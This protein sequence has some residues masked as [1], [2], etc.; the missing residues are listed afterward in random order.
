[1]SIT[2]RFHNEADIA[3]AQLG[4]AVIAARY[5]GKWVFCRHKER[6]TYEIPGG[7]REPGEDIT[8]TARRELYE[9]TGA[10]DFTLLPVGLYSVTKENVSTYGAFFSADIK[11]LG[12]LPAEMEMAEIIFSD[13]LPAELTYPDIYPALFK[14]VCE[15]K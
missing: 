3:D 8:D 12:A 5:K 7:H 1:L 9:E 4:F 14:R 2:V 13:T 10:L 15:L 11:K 6:S